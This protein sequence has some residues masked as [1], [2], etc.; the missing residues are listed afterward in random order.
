MKKIIGMKKAG[1]FAFIMIMGLQWSFA[2]DQGIYTQYMLNPVLINPAATG[3]NEDHELFFNYRNQ[4]SGTDGTPNNYTV[5]YNGRVYDNVGLGLMANAET[6]GA[7]NRYRALLS[8]AYQ[9][10]SDDFSL[11]IGL[12]TEYHQF[13]L[14]GNTLVNP[15]VQIDDPI[16]LEAADGLQFFDVSFGIWGEVKE[17]FVFGFAMPNLVRTR[18]D[19]PTIETDAESTSFKFFNLFTGYKFAL[20]EYDMKVYPSILVKR[21]F[22]GPE[23]VHA[24]LNLLVSFLDE[25]LTGGLS[26]QIGGSQRLGFLIGTKIDEFS[27]YYSYDAS[28]NP[29]QNYT[30]GSH[31]ITVGFTLGGRSEEV[32]DEPEEM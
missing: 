21:V 22:M 3:F 17:R 13:S 11:G 28:F 26:Y 14:S 18:I 30:S 6:F 27:L 32:E 15:R 29:L 31:E 8:Y 9:I 20:E 24:D 7:L 16:L 25:Q 1:V 12:S 5:S 4:W 2:Q 10:Q 23:D 19:N